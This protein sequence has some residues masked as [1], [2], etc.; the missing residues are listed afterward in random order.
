MAH[1]GSLG[2]PRAN[3]TTTFDYFGVEIT[4]NTV[5]DLDYADFMEEI[6]DL[7][8]EDPRSRRFLKEF[9]TFCL[10]GDA[11]RFWQLARENRQ[12]QEDV[13]GVLTAL[14]EA[15]SGRPTGQPSGSSDGQ[16][17]TAPKSTVDSSLGGRLDGRPDL[18]VFITKAAEAS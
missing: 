14:V 16:Q 3:E 7:T 4:A 9:A 2:V 17:P 13:F 15:H 1:L 11:E 8:P 5:T 12:S 6:G 10:G 18:Q